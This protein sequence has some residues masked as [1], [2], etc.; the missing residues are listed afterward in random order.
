MKEVKNNRVAGPFEKIPFENYIQSPI[1]LVPKRGSDQTRLIFHLSYEFKKKNRGSVNQFTPKDQCIVK[2]TDIDHAVRNY[3][4]LASEI[5][6]P[7]E[8]DDAVMES[9]KLDCKGRK[10]TKNEEKYYIKKKKRLN[11]RSQMKS[12]IFAGKS[13]LKSAFR[14]LPISRD[15]W[16]WLVMKAQDPTTGTWKYFVDKCL[17]FGASISCSHFQRFSNALRH[18]AEE[19]LKAKNRITNYIDDFLFLATSKT[20]CEAMIQGFLELCDELGIPVSMDKTEWSSERM[21]FLGILLDGKSL[22]LSIPIEKRDKA[23]YLLNKM[24]DKKKAMVLEIQQL[25]GY[26]NFLSK[27]IFP[28]RPFIRRMYSK[29]SDIVDLQ[30]HSHPVELRHS[31][32]LKR[33]HHIR[34]DAESKYDCSVWRDFLCSPIK[35]AVNWLMVDLLG[36]IETS[37]TICF[38]SATSAA[39]DNG[40]GCILDQRWI[41][42][43]WGESFIKNEKPSIEY[44]ELFGLVA[45][46]FTWQHHHLLTNSR[47][48]VVCDN[49]AV[50]H[51]INSMT[52][53]CWNCMILIR[54]MILNGLKYNRRVSARYVSSK[55][56]FLADLL[57]CGYYK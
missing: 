9:Q 23:I 5:D 32:R 17:P 8:E 22:T 13:D 51:M 16:Q 2:Y 19:R 18:L 47:I 42:G 27:A 35:T 34:I 37:K 7:N 24:I 57:S 50:V 44:L 33:Y 38:Y 55:A 49:M 31:H 6:C 26:L 40:F 10:R 15:S 20:S 36:V 30:N 46:L 4:L 54:L 41:A 56:N 28:G 29:F 45:G 14:L 52:S 39:K 25:C 53:S 12:V 1:G 43:L 11:I 48:A 3:L 21:V